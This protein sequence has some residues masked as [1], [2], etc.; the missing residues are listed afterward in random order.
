MRY[1][2]ILLVDDDRDDRELFSYVLR[3]L[4]P[5]LECYMA[6]DGEEAVELL[7]GRL[8]NPDIIFLDLNMPRMNGKKFL[9]WIKRNDILRNIP[10]IIYSTSKSLD[11]IEETRQLGALHFITKPDCIDDILVAIRYV[12]GTKLQEEDRFYLNFN[13]I[14]KGY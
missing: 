1:T 14:T 10:V 6:R 8:A 3:K 11:D 9:Q 2:R 7:T 13:R 4:D 5:H 12:M